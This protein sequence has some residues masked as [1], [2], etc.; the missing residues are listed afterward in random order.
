MAAVD[1]VD[2]AQRLVVVPVWQRGNPSG[3]LTPA[4]LYKDYQPFIPT[5]G[6]IHA[7]VGSNTLPYFASKVGGLE[8]GSV[9]DG[10]YVCAHQLIP[11]DDY[12]IY[13]MVPAGYGCAHA[14]PASW[15]ALV[16]NFNTRMFGFELENLQNGRDP[17]TEAQYIKLALS[18]AY[19][20]ALHQ[21]SDL[22]LCSHHSAAPGHRTDP[23][24][25]AFYYSLFYGHLWEIRNTPALYALWNLPQWKG[26]YE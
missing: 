15:G 19:K 8:A 3:Y 24:S 20:S 6:V 9:R 18:W 26:G 17:F 12:T 16:N 22:M 1:Y 2:Y 4:V 25:G 23:D 11:K 21:L 7:T 10:R 14:Y 5:G 13:D